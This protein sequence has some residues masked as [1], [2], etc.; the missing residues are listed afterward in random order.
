[1]WS[2][3]KRVPL[4]DRL[5]AFIET[6]SA[7]FEEIRLDRL[8]TE[9][10]AR[11]RQRVI[12]RHEAEKKR[13]EVEEFQRSNLLESTKKWHEAGQI[14]AYLDALEAKIA[15]GKIRPQE[16]EHFRKFLAWARWYAEDLDPLSFPEPLPESPNPEPQNTAISDLDL[17]RRAKEAMSALA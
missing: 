16:P 1:R 2:D 12:E 9:C 13:R 15:S 10:R 11:Q 7:H 8:D 5:G 4:E 14:R 17:T 6:C 3:A